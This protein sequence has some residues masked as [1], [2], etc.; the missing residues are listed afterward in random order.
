M[1]E[2][3][4][5]TVNEFRREKDQFYKTGHESPIP[6]N[7]RASFEGLKYF[8][9][10]KH[11]VINAKLKRYEKPNIVTMTTSKGTVQKFYRMGYF[12]FEISKTKVV[13]QAYR[14]AEREDDSLFVPFRD[15]TS[16]KESYG[17]S[18]YLDL[19]MKKDSDNYVLDFNAAYNPYC[20]YS[21]DY[22]C[23]FAPK[24]NWLSVE[25]KAGEK[26]YHD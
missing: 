4:D 6:E 8:S 9:P 7:E 2:D 21:N 22:V 12:E 26:K 10:D 17:S 13:L 19:D 20:A 23:P 25:I 15:K 11:Y 18:R 1:A 14:S 24:E 5:T 3:W 16:G